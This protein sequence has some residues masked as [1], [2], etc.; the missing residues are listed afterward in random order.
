MYP[1]RNMS[2][3]ASSW[4]EG[5]VGR[6][7]WVRNKDVEE[8]LARNVTNYRHDSHHWSHSIQSLSPW[9]Q[10]M[11]K[12][13]RLKTVIFSLQ[14]NHDEWQWQRANGKHLVALFSVAPYRSL[15]LQILGE[16]GK[17]LHH[18]T[19]RRSQQS[20]QGI[21]FCVIH[22]DNKVVAGW[23]FSRFKQWWLH[24]KWQIIWIEETVQLS[25]IS[26]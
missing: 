26:I 9:F 6:M 25:V 18:L 17:K 11:Q 1:V 2:S 4:E 24:S 14:W 20:V 22:A 12:K 16:S 13:Q 19:R 8:E 7:W 15:S 21:D 10:E 23:I 3:E 5:W